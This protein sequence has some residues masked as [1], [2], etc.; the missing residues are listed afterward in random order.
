M[1]VRDSS[2]VMFT[3]LFLWKY[4]CRISLVYS[5]SVDET[6]VRRSYETLRRCKVGGRERESEKESNVCGE[7]VSHLFSFLFLLFP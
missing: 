3:K 1:V 6:K 4:C 5:D 2:F 7:A